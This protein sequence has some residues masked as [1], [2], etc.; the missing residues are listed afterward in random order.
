META[1]FFSF[2]SIA[3]RRCV[4]ASLASDRHWVVLFAIIQQEVQTVVW[5]RT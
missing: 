2:P 1:T 3:P 5:A 4:I